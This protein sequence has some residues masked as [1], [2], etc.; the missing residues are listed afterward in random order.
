MDRHLARADETRKWPRR[1]W[2]DRD[3]L[4]LSGAVATPASVPASASA[5]GLT[6][7]PRGAL[8][9]W[10]QISNGKISRY[11]II[12]PCWNA[13]K[14]ASGRWAPSK[15]LSGR[16]ADIK[17]PIEVVRVITPLTVSFLRST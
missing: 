3:G 6:E 11:Q 12:T 7:A 15:A 9:H 8:G 14:D 17:Q 4:N 10:L 13:L 1:P 5:I 2:A 16:R